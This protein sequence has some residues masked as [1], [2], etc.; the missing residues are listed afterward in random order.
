MNKIVQELKVEFRSNK[1]KLNKTK[2]TKNPNKLTNKLKTTQTQTKGILK[3]EN[4]CQKTEN[5]ETLI[6]KR[7]YEMERKSQT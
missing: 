3:T 5:T 2:P 7:T 6:T 1:N 4:L